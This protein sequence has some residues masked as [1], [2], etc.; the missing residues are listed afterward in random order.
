MATASSGS[1]LIAAGEKREDINTTCYFYF[2]SGALC[3]RGHKKLKKTCHCVGSVQVY[4]AMSFHS[5]W[6]TPTTCSLLQPLTSQSTQQ[7]QTLS[8]PGEGD[9]HC[10]L[11][12]HPIPTPHR[13][14]ASVGG[15]RGAALWDENGAFPTPTGESHL[16]PRGGAHRARLHAAMHQHAATQRMA[17]QPFIQTQQK[18]NE[19]IRYQLIDKEGFIERSNVC[20]QN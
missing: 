14:P 17:K 7:L 12:S 20:S 8:S 10:P 11:H 19:F 6:S 3:W 13:G 1:W 2:L 18:N 15:G 16:I 9:L 5:A 4:G